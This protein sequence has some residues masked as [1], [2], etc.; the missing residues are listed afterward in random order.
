MNVNAVLEEEV[1]EIIK[2]PFVNLFEDNV[3]KYRNVRLLFESPTF[4]IIE[5][6]GQRPNTPDRE[7]RIIEKDKGWTIHWAG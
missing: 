2:C 7:A 1:E 4:W 5:K 3:L 6:A